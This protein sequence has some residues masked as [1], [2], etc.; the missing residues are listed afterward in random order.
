MK[1]L[2]SRAIERGRGGREL[3]AD[4]VRRELESRYF[5]EHEHAFTTPAPEIRDRAGDH[6]V[7]DD[8][9]D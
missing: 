2:A 6:L 7:V 8:F 4:P 3:F 1:S 9:R 5:R